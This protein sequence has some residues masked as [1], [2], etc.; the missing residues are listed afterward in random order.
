VTL[1]ASLAGSQRRLMTAED[2][3]LWP[4][5]GSRHCLIDGLLMSEPSP[6]FEHGAVAAAITEILRAHTRKTGRGF[7]LTCDPGFLIGRDPDTV[8][9]PDVAYL[10]RERIPSR[11]RQARPWP[12]VA[13]DL[14]VEVRSGSDSQAALLDKAGRWLRAGTRVVWIVDPSARTLL[15]LESG[16]EPVLYSDGETVPGE[17]VLPALRV[18]VCDLWLE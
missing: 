17:P 18:P 10:A 3:A 1:K 12:E 2:L 11:L 6:G 13:P 5:D 14:V 8:L 15:V 16:R 9:A 7:V 4:D